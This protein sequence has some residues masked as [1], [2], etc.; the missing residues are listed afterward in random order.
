MPGF[1][2]HPAILLAALGALS[3]YAGTH[4]LNVNYGDAPRLGLYMILPGIWFGCVVGF[5]V[6][7]FGSG[8][9]F[10]FVM[11]VAT[12]W[13]AWEVAVNLAMQVTE[14]WLKPTGISSALA[15]SIG[16]L[17]AGMAGAFLTWAGAASFTPRL[18]R[19]DLS[20]AIVVT[21]AILGLLL[22]PANQY[23]FPALLFVP[24][25]GAVAAVLGTGL[26]N[27]NVREDF[28]RERLA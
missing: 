17:A 6:C 25:Q 14:S 15:V 1:V 22:Q 27:Q 13:I 24:W 2:R 18:R 10:K 19:F 28:G 7:H 12:T 20:V 3:G 21:G 23:D 9:L 11:A 5:G 4:W 26:G 8:S 16:G